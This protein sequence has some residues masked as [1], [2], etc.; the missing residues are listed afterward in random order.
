MIPQQQQ[1]QQQ[2]RP[3]Q[4]RRR[5][6]FQMDAMG[7]VKQTSAL[8]KHRL[9]Y[10]DKER[11]W[12]QPSDFAASRQEA[13]QVAKSIH[14]GSDFLWLRGGRTPYAKSISRAYRAC[15]RNSPMATSQHD[16]V[17]ENDD[18]I[19]NQAQHHQE[20]QENDEQERLAQVDW[21]GHQV[22]DD[23]EFWVSVGGCRR[24]LERLMLPNL[25]GNK[26]QRRS[27]VVDSVLFVQQE[28]WE[29]GMSYDASSELMSVASEQS[30]RASIRFARAL[31]AADAVAAAALSEDIAGIAEEVAGEAA[32]WV[33]KTS[34]FQSNIEYTPLGS[35]YYQRRILNSAA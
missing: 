28:C 17:D 20:Q 2:Q 12:W 18:T 7:E 14:G 31:G 34:G 30:S 25:K 29:R 19:N 33:K 24:G 9:L 21:M 27:D 32:E 5:V 16:E 15:A 6:Q 26:S 22:R 13:I 1:Q 11:C 23:L 3:Q 35:P 10:S 8:P 4:G